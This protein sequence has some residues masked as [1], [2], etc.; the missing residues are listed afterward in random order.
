MKQLLTSLILLIG[1]AATAH[2]QSGNMLSRALWASIATKPSS[3]ELTTNSTYMTY[4]GKVLV[5]WR[6][7]PGDDEN[8][9]FDLYRKIGS[10]TETQLNIKA[11]FMGGLHYEVNP[12][13][14]T[15]YQDNP[16]SKTQDI[17]YRLT[18]SGS[19]ETLATY[20]ITRQQLQSGLPYIS[21]PLQPTSDVYDNPD[22]FEY[23]ANDASVGDL[24][25]DGEME[26]VVKR[27]VAPKGVL[28]SGT[29]A[30]DSDPKVRHTVIFDAYKLDGTLLWRVKSGPNIILGNS[31]NFGVA[32]L[33]G[34]GCAEVVTKTG[35]GTV[36]GDGKEIGDTNG[37][38][39][40]DYR[41]VWP[42]SHYTGD[43]P[44]GYGGPEFFSVIDG[45]TGRE[46]ARANFI[47][48]APEGQTEAQMAAN[49]NANDMLWDN[50]TSRYYWKLANSLR[51]GI[52]SFDGRKN[53]IFLGRGIYARSV[54]E[55]WNYE[56]TPDGDFEGTLT[57]LWRFDT[58]TA[59]GKDTNK[60]GK[61]NSAYAA[62]GNHAFNAADLDGDG[63]DEI[64]YGSCA[65][66]NDGTGLWTSG[67][68]HGD[69]NHVGKF[70]PE[71]DGLQVFHC[72]ENG[73]PWVALH[74]AKDGSVIWQRNGTS[75]NDMGRCMVDDIDPSSPGCEFWWPYASDYSAFA[76]NGT[77]ALGFKPSSANMAI[78]YDGTLSRQLMNE[79]IINNDRNG[80]RIFTMYRYSERF[81]NGT[82]SNPSWYGDMLG[83]WRE[84]I[85]VPDQTLVGDLKVFSTW[86]PTDHRFPWLMTDHTYYMQSVNE[87]VGYNQ[88]THTGF[89]LGSDLTSDSE[90]W[91]AFRQQ[92]QP[93]FDNYQSLKVYGLGGV[94]GITTVTSKQ[95]ADDYYYTL[96]GR[97]MTSKPTRGMY[98]YKGRKYVSKQ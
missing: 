52:A 15:N 94:T 48:R 87:C 51:L 75:A 24:D 89:Y 80:G 38:G 1:F 14:A 5:S 9:T 56:P 26:I 41:S 3:G 33:D 68:G 82:K 7:L 2:A 6:M 27:L 59:G 84:E 8:T 55:G 12:I 70:L 78:W 69:A 53:H 62:Q 47:S 34:D 65:F 90:A 11:S 95:P 50:R 74:D 88:P 81:I 16:S 76:S 10:G 93:Y 61:L 58:S 67:L 57:R 72:L 37:D 4:Y 44:K 63:C 19:D 79:N 29:G 39:K 18:Y 23:Q 43:G 22:E 30:S 25:G 17:T 21:I 40:T 66:D 36:F 71:R 54:V 92:N 97:R 46:L 85:I 83:D 91:A 35:E 60:D 13:A 28:D 98:I 96:D 49:W 20:T 45:K 31:I 77:K 86:Y 73:L 32:D 42:V 64:M